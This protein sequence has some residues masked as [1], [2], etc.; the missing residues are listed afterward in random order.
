[1]RAK[2]NI[3]SQDRNKSENI[4]DLLIDLAWLSQKSVYLETVGASVVYQVQG[5]WPRA[6][7]EK[8]GKIMCVEN[9]HD[10][11]EALQN[12]APTGLYVPVQAHL[13]PEIVR[14]IILRHHLAKTIF[15]EVDGKQS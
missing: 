11:E 5:G 2:V 8:T 1:M 12:P 7:L 9:V 15:W 10:F 4:P 6:I 13:T 3:V 14:R